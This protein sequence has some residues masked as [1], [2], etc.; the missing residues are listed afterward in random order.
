MAEF[1]DNLTKALYVVK[2]PGSLTFIIPKY[3]QL[4]PGSCR[5]EIYPSTE[6]GILIV[7]LAPFC[8]GI[9]ELEDFQIPSDKDSITIGFAFTL[10]DNY[11]AALAVSFTLTQRQIIEMLQNY[12]KITSMD[13]LLNRNSYT[14]H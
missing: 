14:E 10:S 1:P 9:A 13:M 5:L 6:P 2:A 8:Y 7:K 3:I 11:T 12:A 4:S